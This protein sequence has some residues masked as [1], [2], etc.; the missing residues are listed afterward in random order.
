MPTKGSYNNTSACTD[1]NQTASYFGDSVLTLRQIYKV[2]DNVFEVMSVVSQDGPT[3]SHAECIEKLVQ[4]PILLQFLSKDLKKTPRVT[5]ST[6]SR[7]IHHEDESELSASVD[8]ISLPL[9]PIARI[10]LPSNEPTRSVLKNNSNSNNLMVESKGSGHS[11]L[12][13]GRQHFRVPWSRRN[14]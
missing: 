6:V 9:T 10:R 7:V 3:M 14:K 13:G 4:D 1:L 12:S 5:F 11:S 8:T 2:V